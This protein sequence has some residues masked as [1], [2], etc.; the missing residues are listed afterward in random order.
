[1][2][3]AKISAAFV[4]GISDGVHRHLQAAIDPEPSGGRERLTSANDHNRDRV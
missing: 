3:L 1:M 4:I 2:P